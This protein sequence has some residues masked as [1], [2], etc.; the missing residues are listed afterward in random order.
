MQALESFLTLFL[1]VFVY[2]LPTVIAWRRKKVSMAQIFIGNLLFG[3]TVI[4]W[5]IMFW[6][7]L[8]TS[9]ADQMNRGVQVYNH[10]AKN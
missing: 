2:F 4:G 3:W 5:F 10:A 7:S 8:G 9:A 1:V 6:K